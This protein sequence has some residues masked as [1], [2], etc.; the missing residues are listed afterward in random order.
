MRRRS[1]SFLPQ[2]YGFQPGASGPSGCPAQPVPVTRQ[3]VPS[4]ILPASFPLTPR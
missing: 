2:E 4:A 3:P 1:G